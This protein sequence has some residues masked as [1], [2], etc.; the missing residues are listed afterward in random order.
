[1]AML[2]DLAV[3]VWHQGFVPDLSHYSGGALCRAAYT[4]D[5]LKCFFEGFEDQQLSELKEQLA[6]AKENLTYYPNDTAT[7]RNFDDV[8]TEWGLARGAQVSKVPGFLDAQ[9]RSFSNAS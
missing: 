2:Y 1:M 4:V 7:K 6:S 8:A 3:G 9:R 5:T